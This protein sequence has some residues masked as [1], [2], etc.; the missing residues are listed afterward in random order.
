MEAAGFWPACFVVAEA[1]AERCAGLRASNAHVGMCS[2]GSMRIEVASGTGRK[3]GR[4]KERH[5]GSTPGPDVVEDG[6]DAGQKGPP[7][8]G[9]IPGRT[10]AVQLAL[11]RPQWVPP[12]GNAVRRGQS[13][14]WLKRTFVDRLAPNSALLSIAA[15][16]RARWN[17][18]GALEGPVC[19]WRRPA[20][21]GRGG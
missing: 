15:C 3:E 9:V 11:G 12:V 17:V 14:G 2:W 6:R 10:T 7:P 5:C 21:C 18:A 20:C 1:D 8:P 4:E 16:V 13:G 19:G